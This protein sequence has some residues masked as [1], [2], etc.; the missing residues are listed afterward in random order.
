MKILHCIHFTIFEAL[1]KDENFYM[2]FPPVHPKSPLFDPG[3]FC[4]TIEAENIDT[5]ARPSNVARHRHHTLITKMH[6]DT[7]NDVKL[8]F[9]S[10]GD[11]PTLSPLPL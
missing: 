5:L 1:Y 10:Y 6:A 11:F 2:I 9:A 4:S 8:P 7:K 3:L